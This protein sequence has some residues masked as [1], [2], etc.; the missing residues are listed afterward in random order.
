MWWE[1]SNT[2]EG[3]RC[4]C[5]SGLWLEKAKSEADS[6]PGRVFKTALVW[7]YWCLWK[8]SW[9]SLL[10]GGWGWWTLW[11]WEPFLDHFWQCVFKF[12]CLVLQAFYKLAAVGRSVPMGLGAIKDHVTMFPRKQN[13]IL[14]S[15]RHVITAVIIAIIF[16]A[17]VL[18]VKVVKLFLLH[19]QSSLFCCFF[20]IC[21]LSAIEQLPEMW[22]GHRMQ[23]VIPLS[24]F[25]VT[26][27]CVWAAF[28]SAANQWSWS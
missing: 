16:D 11:V 20:P 26:L 6:S 23:K 1:Q 24:F 9:H 18:N 10:P 27:R 19:F 15:P 7:L 25:P 13:A 4:W 22:W 21:A 12:R 8:S 2:V 5:T 17:S 28:I 3:S 14:L